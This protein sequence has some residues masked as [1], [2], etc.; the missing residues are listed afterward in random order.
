MGKLI[1]VSYRLPYRFSIVEGKLKTTQ[2]SGGLATA[3]H[4][5]FEKEK[6]TEGLFNSFHWV[7]V[8]DLSKKKFDRVSPSPFVNDNG[9]TLH[10]IFIEG[11][12]S[13]LFYNGFCNS[14]LWPLFHYF[15]S[16]VIYKQEFFD[17]YQRANQIMHHKITE[18][19][20]P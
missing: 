7:G 13:D 12:T 1:I 8:S 17:A 19:Y 5:F 10:P 15:P 9:L 20:S 6:A 14:V 18:L 16:N 4:S 2:S 11:R 3:L